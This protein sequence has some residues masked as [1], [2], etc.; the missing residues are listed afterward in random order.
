MNCNHGDENVVL[1]YGVGEKVVL[2]ENYNYVS[3]K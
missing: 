3:L 2:P 1:F